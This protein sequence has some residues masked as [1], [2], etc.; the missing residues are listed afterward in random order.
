MPDVSLE[1]TENSPVQRSAARLQAIFGDPPPFAV[2]LGSGLSPLTD[3]L[4][5]PRSC[6]R[7]EAALPP[8]G[9]HGHAGT[10][11]RGELG[12]HPILALCGRNHLYEGHSVATAVQ[13]VRSLARW[14]VKTLVLTSAV[15]GIR[16]DLRPGTLARIS[17]HINFSGVNPLAGH[18]P[19]HPAERFID[20][21]RLYAPRLRALLPDLPE[22]VYAMMPGPTYE[23]PAEIRMLGRMGADVVGMSMVQEAIAAYAAGMEVLSLSVI[24]NLAAGISTTPLTHEEVTEVTRGA[25]ARLE[26]ALCTVM[27]A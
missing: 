1:D 14:G 24:S 7:A 12:G 27:A 21:S 13:A 9:V 8:T 20:I 26:A 5:A 19:D 18:S 25:L 11:V 23:S 2:V 22:A 10:L 16:P 6:S 15:G 3:R 17:D 4:T